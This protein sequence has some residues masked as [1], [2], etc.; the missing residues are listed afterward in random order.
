MEHFSEQPWADFVRGISAPEISKDIKAH[1]AADCSKCKTALDAWSRV[2]RLASAED[3]YAP[4]ENLVRLVKLG[5]AASPHISPG[6]CSANWTLA[7]L[8]FDSFAQPLPAG[9]R[10]A[11]TQR[12]AG[13]L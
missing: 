7:N 5:F 9:V 11:R 6:L 3:A 1:L 4:P 8:V 12:M 2:R 10:S 13:R